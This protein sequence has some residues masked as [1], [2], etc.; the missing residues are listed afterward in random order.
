MAGALPDTAGVGRNRSETDVIR[1]LE[2]KLG[3]A[4]RLL[5]HVRLTNPAGGDVE[6]D[7]LLML[8]GYGFA[9]VEVKGGVLSFVQGEWTVATATG[10][11]RVHPTE[12]ARN[13]KHV[14][15]AFLSRQEP[16]LGS[17]PHTEWFIAAPYTE[18][19][20]DMGPEAIREVLIG[21]GNSTL[22]SIASNSD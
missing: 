3:P 18:I 7:V 6:I 9:V 21:I 5:S 20:G 4:D 17:L 2:R 11:R 13:G 12:Q 15:R 14:L 16:W 8:P 1:A 19:T 22:R 10:K